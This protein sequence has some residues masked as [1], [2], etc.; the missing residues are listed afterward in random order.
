MHKRKIS[1]HLPLEDFEMVINIPDGED[2]EEHVDY[3]LDQ[4]LEY[5]CYLV[6]EWDF[7]D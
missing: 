4:I 3:L 7:V 5:D 2:D 1:V 6:M